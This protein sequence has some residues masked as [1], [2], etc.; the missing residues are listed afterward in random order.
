MK[1]HAKAAFLR[2]IDDAEYR[3]AVN[4]WIA[5][6]STL[7]DEVGKIPG[8]AKPMPKDSGPLIFAFRAQQRPSPSN[9]FS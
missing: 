6:H 2:V 1:K 7:V 3:L 4:A 9:P 8:K 5:S